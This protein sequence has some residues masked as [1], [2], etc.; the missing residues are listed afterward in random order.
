M[1]QKASEL[2]ASRL[3]S[4]DSYLTIPQ[5]RHRGFNSSL[6]SNDSRQEDD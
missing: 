4:R 3:A 6:G 2:Q 1:I 5:S